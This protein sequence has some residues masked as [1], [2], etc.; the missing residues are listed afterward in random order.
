MLRLKPGEY[1][2]EVSPAARGLLEVYARHD[3]HLADRSERGDRCG[4]CCV[5]RYSA[6]DDRAVGEVWRANGDYDYAAG[7]DARRR[8]VER[9]RRWLDAEEARARSL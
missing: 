4:R 8:A 1:T 5:A 3:S 6:E 9:W 7:A 2:A